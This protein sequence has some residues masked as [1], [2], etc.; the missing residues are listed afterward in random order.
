M[1]KRLASLVLLCVVLP[2]C[3]FADETTIKGGSS[4]AGMVVGK[5]DAD[6]AVSY[7]FSPYLNVVYTSQNAFRS[8]LKASA[9][10]V[11]VP[12]YGRSTSFSLDKAYVRFRIPTFGNLKL[13]TIAGKAPVSWGMGQLYRGGDILFEKPLSNS[14]AGVDVENT[15][16]VLSLSQSLGN[17]L[18]AELAFVPAVED[19]PNERIGAL[20]KKS[21]MD[22]V[23]SDYLKEVRLAYV[24]EP[25]ASDSHRASVL[26]DMNLF[27]DLNVCI[28]SR[29]RDSKDVR[30]VVNAM[31]AF[32]I[33]TEL[34]SHT[35][36]AYVS[37]QGDFHEGSH[38][39]CGYLSFDATDRL[40]LAVVQSNSWKDDSYTFGCTLSSSLSVASGVDASVIA[41]V[42]RT[43]DLDP[44]FAIGGGLEYSF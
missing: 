28:E 23:V 44:S 7:M 31:R 22:G 11:N 9:N 15:L 12:V 29:F 8:E 35:L 38:D 36:T 10:V 2:L 30:L 19:V 40:S 34:S 21:F 43:G 37:Y 13:T 42:S 33:D 25:K 32:A 41:N 5:S 18:S 17:G 24:Y 3:L 4:L 1:V 20:V 26:M 27:V 16:W 14:E 6:P 39:L